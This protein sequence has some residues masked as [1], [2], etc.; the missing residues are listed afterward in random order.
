MMIYLIKNKNFHLF[1]FLFCGIFIISNNSNKVFASNENLKKIFA[2]EKFEMAPKGVSTSYNPSNISPITTMPFEMS[3]PL[4]NY[5]LYRENK[6]N[7]LAEVID[8]AIKEVTAEN[9]VDGMCE[10]LH[11]DNYRAKAKRWEGTCDRWSAFHASNKAVDLITSSKGYICGSLFIESVDIAEYLTAVYPS[12]Y[13]EFFGRRTTIYSEESETNELIS[14]ALDIAGHIGL[15]PHQA[16][17]AYS[18]NIGDKNKRLVTDIDPTSEVWNQPTYGFERTDVDDVIRSS[19]SAELPMMNMLID[20]QF[21]G[22]SYFYEG[23]TSNA[24]N[25]LKKLDNIDKTLLKLVKYIVPLKPQT[26]DYEIPK[27]FVFFDDIQKIIDKEERKLNKIITKLES[28]KEEIFNNISSEGIRIRSDFNAVKVS[29]NVKFLLEESYRRGYKPRLGKMDLKYFVFEDKKTKKLYSKWQ[30]ERT[31]ASYPDF[32]WQ[33][34]CQDE[35]CAAEAIKYRKAFSKADINKKLKW[36]DIGREIATD[37]IFKL[38]EKCLSLD[39][40]T[41]IIPQLLDVAT[42]INSIYELTSEE[43]DNFIDL[44]NKIKLIN[45]IKIKGLDAALEK[46]IAGIIIDKKTKEMSF[47]DWDEKSGKCVSLN[48]NGEINVLKNNICKIDENSYFKKDAFFDDVCYENV[49]SN[50]EEKKLRKVPSI[51]CK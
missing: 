44:Y 10:F 25:G 47:A 17:Q 16:D 34:K 5:I 3:T 32:I 45:K 51:L 14:K 37:N 48:K 15:S 9:C 27:D 29:A 31:Y 43:R 36:S 30:G 26:I 23:L 46:R 7:T 12:D 41:K 8:Q 19:K 28:V 22:N 49:K 21:F 18:Q 35:Y 33:P 40:A 24:N 4:S 42:K 38:L 2:I 20:G 11:K 50:L 6:R 39:E 1:L 13:E